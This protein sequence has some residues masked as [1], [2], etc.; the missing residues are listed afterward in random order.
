MTA[1]PVT[2]TTSASTTA[3]S[4]AA[5]PAVLLVD[6]HDLFRAGLRQL[7][8]AQGVRVVGDSRCE[9]SAVDM[10]RRTRT[11]VA[12]FDTQTVDGSSTA[13]L[14]EAFTTE[15]PTAGVVMFSRSTERDDVYRS[16]R[17]G[18]RGYLAK[19]APVEQLAGAI[20]AV[21]AGAAW[22]QP[23]VI[24][25]ALEFIRTGQL[26]I[27]P[28]SDMSE[29]EIEVLRLIADGKDNNDIA[30]ELGIS[31]KTVKNHV[32]SILMKL[33]LTNRVQAAVFAVRAG[34]S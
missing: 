24:A 32:S 31:P 26:P 1:R 33:G 25:T 18:A 23:T 19:G 14:V 6:D 9:P 11:T 10:G 34:L 17:A 16:I 4:G 29:R 21:H 2:G 22:M 30:A 7:L 5:V 15:L 8:E 28:R 12:L 27:T 20:R 3:P 13:P